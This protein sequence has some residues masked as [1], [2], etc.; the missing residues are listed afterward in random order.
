LTKKTTLNTVL[1]IRHGSSP[2]VIYVTGE[3]LDQLAIRTESQCDNM[4]SPYLGDIEFLVQLQD[5]I[6][7]LIPVGRSMFDG[8]CN[9]LAI[10]QF[11]VTLLKTVTVEAK[12]WRGGHR[13]ILEP[14]RQYDFQ[15]KIISASALP[16]ETIPMAIILTAN[17][18]LFRWN[19][20]DGVTL[21]SEDP[22]CGYSSL[23]P[24][25]TAAPLP[26][27]QYSQHPEICHVAA[28]KNLFIR[29]FR[30]AE[31]QVLFSMESNY[32]LN[33]IQLDSNS[34]LTEHYLFACMSGGKMLLVD[35]RFASR[36]LAQR[37]V[38]NDGM[39]LY[40]TSIGESFPSVG[41]LGNKRLPGEGLVL[42]EY[43]TFLI[44]ILH[45]IG[46]IVGGSF[47]SLQSLLHSVSITELCSES[48]YAPYKSFYNACTSLGAVS[49]S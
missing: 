27:V 17:G 16:R 15:D 45:F 1:S 7:G 5:R 12:E 10:S 11:H 4:K 28:C 38:A 26:C 20:S 49:N 43:A 32:I 35:K 37:G 44:Q 29:D 30:Q 22:I 33:T 13:V 23:Y 36:P 46:L 21:S 9:I 34:G 41:P 48:T 39:N 25:D 40:R 47:S 42:I 14:T 8:S 19:V 31:P 3:N 2:L 6:I 18:T 24:S